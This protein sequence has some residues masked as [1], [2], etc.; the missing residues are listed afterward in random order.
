M[1]LPWIIRAY[2]IEYR[3]MSSNHATKAYDLIYIQLIFSST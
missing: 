3:E 2:K 1:D